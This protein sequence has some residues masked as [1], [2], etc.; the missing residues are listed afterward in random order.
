MYDIDMIPYRYWFIL[1]LVISFIIP[2]VIPVIFWD[3][4]VLNAVITQWFLRYPI[5]LN[6]MLMVN[7]IAHHW[8]YR[9]YNR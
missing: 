8:G 9:P 1:G 4:T 2:T 3:E 6:L 5:T 7:S